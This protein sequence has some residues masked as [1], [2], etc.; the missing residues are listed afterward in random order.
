[1]T[2]FLPR[3]SGNP[4]LRRCV[5]SL[6]PTPREPSAGIL[7]GLVAGLAVLAR[8]V[9]ADDPVPPR[10]FG[11]VPSA[12]QLRWHQVEFYGLIHFG[13]NT[14]T[15]REWGFGDDSPDLFAPTAFD[16]QKVVAVA[17]AAGMRGLILVCKH[18]DGFCLW[19]S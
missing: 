10:P 5:P 6:R 13:L 7:A 19:P 16:A 17:Q 8:C 2:P 12:R 14:F 4:C 15:D 3:N 1:M 9:A 18:H 11:A